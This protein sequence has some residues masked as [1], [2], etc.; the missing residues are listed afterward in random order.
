[1]PVTSR[2]AIPRNRAATHPVTL[3]GTPDG[4]G[5]RAFDFGVDVDLG[6][7]VLCFLW[8]SRWAPEG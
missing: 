1:M 5:V 2:P 7:D 3:P 8:A 4:D 6:V